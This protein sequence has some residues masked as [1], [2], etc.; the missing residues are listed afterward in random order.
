MRLKAIP[1][2]VTSILIP[3]LLVTFRV[4]ISLP[5][6]N[7]LEGS[8]CTKVTRLTPQDATKQV[9]AHAQLIVC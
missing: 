8:D 9:I 4:F 2:F 6:D 3:L 1:L 7:C 5:D